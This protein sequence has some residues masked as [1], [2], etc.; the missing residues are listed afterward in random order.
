MVKQKRKSEAIRRA[1][2]AREVMENAFRTFKNVSE[3]ELKDL[4]FLA[5]GAATDF[6]F[7]AQLIE[8][9][10]SDYIDAWDRYRNAMDA[11]YKLRQERESN[12]FR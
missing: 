10:E 7:A 12:E 11:Y 9:A 2:H 5:H 6:Y 1:S 3:Q 8:K 4:L